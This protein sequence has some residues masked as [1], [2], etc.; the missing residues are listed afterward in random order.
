MAALAGR[1]VV[2]C[3][4]VGAE[5]TNKPS[6]GS[7]P[8][9]SAPRQVGR[10]RGVSM[11]AGLWSRLSFMFEL[12]SPTVQY[13]VPTGTLSCAALSR[14]VSRRVATSG[15]GTVLW[16]CGRVLRTGPRPAGRV[17]SP[18][19]TRQTR[20]DHRLPT[21]AGLS[22]TTPQDQQP[23][24]FTCGLYHRNPGVRSSP[25]DWLDITQVTLDQQ[26]FSPNHPVIAQTA[27]DL[28]KTR[29]KTNFTL[30]F[31]LDSGSIQV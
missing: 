19:T 31:S 15:G 18:W 30:T 8:D 21:L 5:R 22:P 28:N 12:R 23:I 10:G 11:A 9:R 3:A 2:K 7:A 25:I 16:I 24:F 4:I 20:V 17:D 27:S 1:L 14:Q 26:R 6:C 29:H 13:C